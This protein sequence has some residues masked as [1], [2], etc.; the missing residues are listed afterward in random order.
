MSKGKI[1]ASFGTTNLAGKGPGSYSGGT[2]KL[3]SDFEK[4]ILSS[5]DEFLLAAER[6]L[7]NGKI[8]DC[9]RILLAPG[10]VCAAFSCELSFKYLIFKASGK[11]A[12]GHKLDALFQQ[13]DTKDQNEVSSFRDN[14]SQFISENNK[15]FVRARYHHENGLFAFKEQEILEF[16]TFMNRIINDK[17]GTGKREI[18]D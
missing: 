12:K 16:A 15:L 9:I 17:H 8:E 11:E 14:F 13:L 6:S 1:I 3:R 18:T 4:D 7:N 5:S 2:I 10:V